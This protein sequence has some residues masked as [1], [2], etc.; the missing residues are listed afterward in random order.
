MSHPLSVLQRAKKSD[1]RTYPYPLIILK[2]ALP[3]ALCEQLIDSYPSFS[4]LGV[5][6]NKNNARWSY[7]T[8]KVLADG[9]IPQIWRDFVA[10]NASTEF[11]HEVVDLFYDQIHDRYPMRFPTR[12][13]MKCLRAG[14]RDRDTLKDKDVL[15]DAQIGGNTP[16]REANSVR[17]SHIDAGDKLFS[18]LLY[19][20]RD[21]DDSKGGDLVISKFKSFYNDEKAKL[22]CF[23]GPYVPDRFLD[24]IET[25]RYAKNVLVLFINTIDSLHGVTV[26]E[27]T[28][29]A[30]IFLNLVGEVG[31]PL[32]EIPH[33]WQM[34]PHIVK[35]KV[36]E[37]FVPRS[38]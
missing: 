21:D 29:H 17:S 31:E 10:Y 4:V 22:S 18:G 2:D 25:V 26:R 7:P 19:L 37:L 11:F 15:M 9:D 24:E 20:R 27:P 34:L 5:N 12:Q 1:V 28:R 6:Q 13:G 32:Y 14:I 38:V 30:R 36:N 35:R 8:E 23:D 3:T 33:R 16:V